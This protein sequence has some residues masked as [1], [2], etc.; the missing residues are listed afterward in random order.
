MNIIQKHLKKPWGYPKMS[1]N[2]LESQ[3]IPKILKYPEESQR[4]PKDVFDSTQTSSAIWPNSK[5]QQ[6]TP[7]KST[8]KNTETIQKWTRIF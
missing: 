6:W 4:I 8:K 3:K 7:F 5:Q 2:L 1:K